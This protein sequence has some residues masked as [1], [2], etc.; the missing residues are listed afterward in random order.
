MS[1]WLKFLWWPR[2]PTADKQSSHREGPP[3]MCSGWLR[4]L[5][6]LQHDDHNTDVIS[7]R[8]AESALAF[9]RAVVREDS[10]P[11]KPYWWN[12]EQKKNLK[13]GQWAE[14][15][16]Y[17]CSAW[18]C[19]QWNSSCHNVLTLPWTAVLRNGKM[20]K[21]FMDTQGLKSKLWLNDTTPSKHRN[22][23]THKEPDSFNSRVELFWMKKRIEFWSN[24]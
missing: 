8:K 6:A 22:A 23:N 20:S 11:L 3:L 5:F 21:Q 15:L 12:P 2:T 13:Q 14:V 7:C 10:L 19:V 9:D 4:P 16:A 18:S 17:L 24:K 1:T